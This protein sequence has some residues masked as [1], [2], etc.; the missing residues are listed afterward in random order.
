MIIDKNGKLGGKIS[1]I[2]LAV[3][4]LILIVIGGLIMRFGSSVTTSV[5]SDAQFEYVVKVDGVREFTVDALEKKGVITDK[6]SEK[7]LGEILDVEVK[8]AQFRSTTADGQI[9]ETILPDRYTCYVTIKATG[10]ESDEGYIM[11][12]SN[13]LSVGRTI[14]IYSKYVKTSG[15]IKSVKV[16]GE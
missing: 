11:G 1:I 5:K 6:K 13:E 12:D 10:K 15:E 2:D 9:V 16:V 3:I 7:I 14:D 4:L 8:D